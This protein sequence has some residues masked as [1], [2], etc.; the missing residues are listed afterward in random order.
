MGANVQCELTSFFRLKLRPPT[1]SGCRFWA[2]PCQVNQLVSASTYH[3]L[4]VAPSELTPAASGRVSHRNDANAQTLDVAN[5]RQDAIGEGVKR[6]QDLGLRQGAEVH[7]QAD[8][9]DADV[10]QH[11]DAFDPLL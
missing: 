11:M 4:G 3:V 2:A 5:V 10:A 6:A 9:G 1:A 8:L 7:Q